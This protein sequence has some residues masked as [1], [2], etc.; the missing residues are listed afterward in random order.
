MV[1][2]HRERRAIDGKD[3]DEFSQPVIQISSQARIFP[4]QGFCL[5][6]STSNG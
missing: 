1:V 2:H 6:A 5:L 3:A 4:G